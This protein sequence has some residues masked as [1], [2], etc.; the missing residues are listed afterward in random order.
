MKSKQ[1]ILV[2][3]AVGVVS[4]VAASI[5][6]S[7]GRKKTDMET[8]QISDDITELFEQ[9][10]LEDPVLRQQVEDFSSPPNILKLFQQHKEQLQS[11][12]DQRYEDRKE[13]DMFFVEYINNKPFYFT[14]ADAIQG[15]TIIEEERAIKKGSYDDITTFMDY[16]IDTHLVFRDWMTE[17]KIPNSVKE[18]EFMEKRS[19]NHGATLTITIYESLGLKVIFLYVPYEDVDFSYEYYGM[20][21]CGD[22]G[23][24]R[25][26]RIDS[27][28]YYKYVVGEWSGYWWPDPKTLG[29]IDEDV[30]RDGYTEIEPFS[31]IDPPVYGRELS[32]LEVFIF[33]AVKGG[34]PALVALLM[35]LKIRHYIRR[36]KR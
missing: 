32:V 6:V 4:I 19:Y 36:K 29:F 26:V 16:A 33:Y 17:I 1:Y 23:G 35:I 9:Q 11:F 28:W 24:S 2:M 18:D 27:H 14:T 34:V 25:I 13:Q 15:T 22:P 5:I 30:R 21:C 3:I 10:L 8:E 7:Y 20:A 12:A 31:E